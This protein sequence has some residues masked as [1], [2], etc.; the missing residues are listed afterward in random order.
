MSKKFALVLFV[1]CVGFTS[2]SQ[3]FLFKATSFSVT[4][5]NA[6]G[7]WSDWT[8]P[9]KSELIIKI[10]GV[11]HRVVVYSEEIQLFNIIKYNEVKKTE[12]DIV[13]S[14]N[15][16]DNN[17][18]ECVVSV[19]TRKNQNNRKQLYITYEDFIIEYNIEFDKQ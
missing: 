8:K 13:S 6:K 14:Y 15:C 9:V 17:G 2:Y 1:L 4:E 11:S 18:I 3:Q 12:T 16:V 5:K 10:D 19:F 7:K